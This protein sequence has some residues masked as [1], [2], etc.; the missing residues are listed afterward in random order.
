MGMNNEVGKVGT[1]ERVH[2]SQELS[3]FTLAQSLAKSKLQ[4]S[5]SD[6]SDRDR[7]SIS[8]ACTLYAGMQ[9]TQEERT[10]SVS[11]AGSGLKYCY[12]R[13]FRTDSRH[14]GANNIAGLLSASVRCAGG[15]QRLKVQCTSCV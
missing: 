4:S 15:S 12:R 7:G 14:H 1:S 3:R 10:W 11:R 13:L 9:A 5:S 8:L 2:Q 6:T